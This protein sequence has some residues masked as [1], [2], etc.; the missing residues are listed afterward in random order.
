[1]YAA[2]EHRGMYCEYTAAILID[3]E[4]YSRFSRLKDNVEYHFYRSKS[5]R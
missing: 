5:T 4:L 3:K 1:M 2:F